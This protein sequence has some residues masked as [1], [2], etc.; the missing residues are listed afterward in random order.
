V[1]LRVRQIDRIG[2]ARH[3]ADQ[4]FVGLQHG[5]VDGFVLE[6][7]GGV[8]FQGSVHA[9]HVD[10]ANLRHH[11]GG[12]QDDHLVEAIL[13]ADRLRHN[14]AETAQQHARTAKRATHLLDP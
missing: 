14:F 3:Q 11:V 6:A 9:Q 8:Q 5:L 1:V 7:L 12:D 4:A 10:R 13:R 2:L